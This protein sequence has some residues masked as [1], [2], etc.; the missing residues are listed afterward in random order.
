MFSKRAPRV[1]FLTEEKFSGVLPRPRR[2]SKFMPSWYKDLQKNGP[3]AIGAGT[4]KACVPMLDALSNGFIVPLWSD[5]YVKRTIEDGNVSIT[6][7]FSSDISELDSHGPEQVGEKFPITSEIFKI[8]NPWRIKTPSN[9]SVLIKSPPHGNNMFN[10][11]E[12]I[13]DTDTFHLPI[14]LPCQW[15]G[16]HEGEWLIPKGTPLYQVIPFKR[17]AFEI[18][19]GVQ[20]EVELQQMKYR[21]Q[22]TF[23]DRYR[24]MFWSK[25][26]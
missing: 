26:K 6:M 9:Y 18:E 21:L 11:L 10:I 8:E 25:R 22:T 17:E 24:N 15:I 12:G 5:L 19:C 2:S 4:A 1:Q 14:N 3:T 13:V 7:T 20:D 16:G 23:K